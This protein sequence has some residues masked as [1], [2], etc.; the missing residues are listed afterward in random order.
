MSLVPL[1]NTSH[2]NDFNYIFCV[3]DAILNPNSQFSVGK[4]CCEYGLFYF[5]IKILGHTI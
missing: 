5:A 1:S 2:L 4:E 3:K